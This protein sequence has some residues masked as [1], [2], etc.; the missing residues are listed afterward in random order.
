MMSMR[1]PSIGRFILVCKQTQS[2][3]VGKWLFN[4]LSAQARTSMESMKTIF[5]GARSYNVIDVTT[6]KA[7]HDTELLFDTHLPCF[8]VQ[9]HSLDLDDTKHTKKCQAVKNNNNHRGCEARYPHEASIILSAKSYNV[10]HYLH[11]RWQFFS[12]LLALSSP[13]LMSQMFAFF[14]LWVPK[15]HSP[16][17]SEHGDWF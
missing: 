17:L 11:I 13:D 4:A 10:C 1:P 2:L 6:N 15:Y 9:P 7:S 8:R 3:S 12:R 14:L 5:Y 16:K